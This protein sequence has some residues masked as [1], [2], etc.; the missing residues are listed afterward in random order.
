M[1]MASDRVGLLR[2]LPPLSSEDCLPRILDWARCRSILD[3]V[4]SY[5]LMFYCGSDL[6]HEI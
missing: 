2:H 4:F 3:L 5:V 1:R 6:E